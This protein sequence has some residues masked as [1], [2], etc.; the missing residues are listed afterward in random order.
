MKVWGAQLLES[1]DQVRTRPL[2]LRCRPPGAMMLQ[3]CGKCSGARLAAGC[4]GLTVEAGAPHPTSSDCFDRAHGKLS[5]R[6][7]AVQD[8]EKLGS[9]KGIVSQSIQ[10]VLQVTDI[11]RFLR[12]WS[13]PSLRS[14]V[15][16]TQ[17]HAGGRS[18]EA[19]YAQL[20]I[21]LTHSPSHRA[22]EL[23]KSMESNGRRYCAAVSVRRRSSPQGENWCQQFLLVS[24]LQ[25][26]TLPRLLTVCASIARC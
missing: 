20:C 1:I 19:T 10:E 6:D 5:S 9:K 18:F 4:C 14:S 26:H 8:V 17:A 15:A 3:A 12:R 13:P 24:R 25:C 2:K 23:L 21:C 11:R 16:R 7:L 22:L